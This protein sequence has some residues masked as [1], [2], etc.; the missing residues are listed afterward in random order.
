M[1]VR[2]LEP[3]EMRRVAW[4]AGLSFLVYGFGNVMVAR[5]SRDAM[6]RAD[7]PS[8]LGLDLHS[9]IVRRR[10]RSL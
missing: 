9:W 6:V 1:G 3:A 7:L 4:I 5:F 2:V 10:V 8:W